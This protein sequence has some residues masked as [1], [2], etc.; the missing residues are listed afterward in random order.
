MNNKSTM[1]PIHWTILS[2]VSSLSVTLGVSILYSRTVFS[3]A[4]AV[5]DEKGEELTESISNWDGVLEKF[6][7]T[8]SRAMGVLGSASASAAQTKAAEGYIAEDIIEAYPEVKGL[9]GLLSPRTV[10]YFEENPET[11]IQLATRWGPKLQVL[12]ERY[13]GFDGLIGH[14][15]GTSVNKRRPSSS[16][17]RPLRGN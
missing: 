3:R 16:G 17:F 14:L 1:L 11:L 6:Q 7:P 13:G 15:G 8:I 10:Q 4:R 2:V 9:L 12:Y 5:I